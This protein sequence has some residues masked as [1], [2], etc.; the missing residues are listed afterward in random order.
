MNIHSHKYSGLANAKV[1]TAG[2][3]PFAYLTNL[4][5][6]IHIAEN[7][8]G[9]LQVVTRKPGAS[10]HAVKSARHV[11]GI[12]RGSGPRRANGV[13]AKF[14]KAGYRP[15]LRKVSGLAV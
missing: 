1:R 8:S 13:A 2:S 12:R 11:T 14:A 10:L 7:P 5:K 3:N 4:L 15:D 6:T 9:G